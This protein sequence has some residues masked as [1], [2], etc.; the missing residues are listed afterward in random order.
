MK[1]M[2]RNERNKK[3]KYIPRCHLFSALFTFP[4]HTNVPFLNVMVSLKNDFTGLGLGLGLG[5][6]EKTAVFTYLFMTS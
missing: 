1:K 2:G 6:A 5:L 3:I 4:R